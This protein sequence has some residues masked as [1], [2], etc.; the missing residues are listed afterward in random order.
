MISLS[1][2]TSISRPQ[3]RLALVSACLLAWL[4]LLVSLPLSAAVDISQQPERFDAGRWLELLPDDE[5]GLPLSELLKPAGQAH[6]WLKN[7]SDGIAIGFSDQIWWLRLHVVNPDQGEFRVLE[8]SR[9]SLGKVGL[10]SR[11]QSGRWVWRETGAQA[12]DLRGDVDAPG[13]AFRLWLPKGQSTHLIRLASTYPLRTPFIISTDNE[14]LRQAQNSAGLFGGGIGMLAGLMLAALLLWPRHLGS[15]VITGFILIQLAMILYA[16][17]DR[18]V[19]GVWWLSIP[20]VQHGVLQL[21]IMLQQMSFVWFTLVFLSERKAIDS[22]WQTTLLSLLGLQAVALMITIVIP[23]HEAVAILPMLTVLS[24][25]LTAMACR[26]PLEK[27]M[28]GAGILFSAAILLTVSRLALAGTLGPANTMI[29]E[30]YQWLLAFHVFHSS[31][32][33]LAMNRV[34]RVPMATND[35]L[36]GRIGL[37]EKRTGK[38]KG[39]IRTLREPPRREVAER[40]LQLPMTVLVVEDNAWVQQV[41]VGLLRKQGVDTVTAE[42]GMEALALLE[43]E[44]KLD[45][46]LM[47]CDLPV[48]DGLSAT[49]VWRQRERELGLPHMPILAV[50]AH[51]SETQRQQALDAGM[52]DFLAKPVDMRKL[53]EA[54]IYWRDNAQGSDS[55]PRDVT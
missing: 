4:L 20:G 47:D 16:L 42:N 30:P 26:P 36:R 3:C 24:S 45:L 49:Q 9:A 13:Y 1:P 21:A 15:G 12:M 53:R 50:T 37:P 31:L 27:R 28:P 11:D 40:E 10:Y 18:G 19:L 22:F 44:H 23:R 39:K 8:L 6:G 33:L 48:L 46:V 14:T 55:G 41:I 17:A 5:P 32:L 7:S 29:I 2:S 52:D 25:L 43:G 54:L 35:S 34:A 38:G 51:V